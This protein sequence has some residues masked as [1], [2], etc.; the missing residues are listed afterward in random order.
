MNEEI[1]QFKRLGRAGRI[2]CLIVDGEPNASDKP[3]LAAAECF[4]PALRFHVAPDGTLSTNPAEPIAADMRSGKDGRRDAF[5]KLAAGIAGVG[6]DELKQRELQRQL[7]RAIIVSAASTG[8]LLTMAGLAFVAVLA[9]RE[10]L[11]QRERATVERDR[12][13]RNFR[14]ARDAVDRFYTKVSEEQLLRA[15]GLQPLRADLLREALEYYRRF[16]SQRRDDPAFA[17]EAAIVQTNVGAILGE[18]GDTEEALAAIREATVALERLHGGSAADARVTSRLYDSLGKEAVILDRLGRT[19]EALACH[20]RALGLF[21]TLPADCPDRTPVQWQWLLTTKGA[22]QAKMGKFAEAAETYER[23]LAATDQAPKE[24]APLGLGLEESSVG[25]VVSFVKPR[26]PAAIADIRIGDR[27]IKMADVELTDGERMAEVRRRMIPGNPLS[28]H[29][30]RGE[31][32][33]DV[34]LTPVYLGD[35][36]TALTKYNIGYLYLQRLRQPERAKPWLAASVDEYRRALLGNSSGTPDVR[37]GLA[38]AACELGTCGY[39]L[40]DGTLEEVGLREGVAAS[41]EN[42]RENP[43]VPRYRTK[44]AINLANLATILQNRGDLGAA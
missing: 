40:G 20:D 8:L 31:K 35:L 32:P 42:V 37:D 14:D 39:Q 1:L 12:A 19:D 36:L 3:G 30:M 2:V 33:I 9:R 24:I 26:S 4:P 6:F 16:L 38:S 25:L 44:L 15:E 28:V 7:R 29:I 43:Q 18:V 23:S 11:S 13:E 41:E 27:I 5:L 17:H 22:Y 21:E 10:A 34:T